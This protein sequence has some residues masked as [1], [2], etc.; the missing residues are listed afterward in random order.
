M[1]KEHIVFDHDTKVT[2]E[3]MQRYLANIQ[4]VLTATRRYIVLMPYA[5][6]DFT[7]F[8]NIEKV[9]DLL[10][11]LWFS[12]HVAVTKNSKKFVSLT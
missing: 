11:R 1:Y 5:N 8:K 12:H 7:D 10:N 4:R 3:S 2:Q 6:L 9:A